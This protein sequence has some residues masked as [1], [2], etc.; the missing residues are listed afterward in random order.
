MLEGAI[1]T[2]GKTGKAQGESNLMDKDLEYCR[3]DAEMFY[4]CFDNLLVEADN[5]DHFKGYILFN[6]KFLQ[7]NQYK[8]T[9]T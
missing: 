1:K 5:V 4:K 2:N 8:K 6:S 3:L 7:F 9:R